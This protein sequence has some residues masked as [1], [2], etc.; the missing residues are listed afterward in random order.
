MGRVAVLLEL[1]LQ[2]G[3]SLFPQQSH[4]SPDRV[5]GEKHPGSV[6]IAADTAL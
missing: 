5:G 2:D 3:S 4:P 1:R 6:A